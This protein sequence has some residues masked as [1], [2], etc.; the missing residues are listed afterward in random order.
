MGHFTIIISFCDHIHLLLNNH[1]CLTILNDPQFSIANL[2]HPSCSNSNGRLLLHRNDSHIHTYFWTQTNDI[3]FPF[4]FSLRLYVE[5]RNKTNITLRYKAFA[6]VPE[7]TSLH[8][9]CKMLS[10]ASH[11][12]GLA[13]RLWKNF[14][15][16]NNQ[17]GISVNN[18]LSLCA[19]VY[20]R[21]NVF[22]PVP[23]LNYLRFDIEAMWWCRKMYACLRVWISSS[24][25][26][27]LNPI[28]FSKN[29]KEE[30]NWKKRRNFN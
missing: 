1:Y 23:A 21:G 29:Y 24:L 25:H 14:Y 6:E 10:L 7:T 9:F 4:L 19:L 8:P 16:T 13:C 20:G 12:F 22:E 30:K 28:D 15:I 17:C 5:N 2:F 11:L 3:H 26:E 18:F 27:A